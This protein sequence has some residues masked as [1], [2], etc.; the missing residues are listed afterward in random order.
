MALE[1]KQ[2]PKI[3][4]AC[5]SLMLLFLT[6]ERGQLATH[7]EIEK[8]TGFGREDKKSPYY[9]I[10]QMVGKK[11]QEER[12]ISIINEV[13]VGYTLATAEEQLHILAEKARRG[14]RQIVRGCIAV[15]SLPDDDATDHQRQIRDA[16]ATSGR[17]AASAILQSN[18]LNEFLMRRKPGE[19]LRIMKRVE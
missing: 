1:F 18:R 3:A 4:K 7:D 9:R 16:L 8:A 2:N 5:E 15:E 6:K 13:M 12:G 14:R 11:H 17:S 19:P 10:V